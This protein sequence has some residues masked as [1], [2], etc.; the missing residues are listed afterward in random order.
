MMIVLWLLFLM[1]LLLSGLNDTLSMALVVG[2]PT[3]LIPTVLI[4]YA[5][6][7]RITRYVV[8]VALMV[9][10]AL[11]IQQAAGAAELHFGIFV[12]LAFLLCYRDWMVVVIAATTIALHHVSFNFLQQAS[13]GPICFTEPGINILITHAAY[14]VAETLVLC[15]LAVLLHKEALQSAELQASVSILTRG[16]AGT[17]G[18]DQPAMQASSLSGVALQ[19]VISVL[20]TAIINVR[21]EISTMAVASNQIATANSS[22]AVRTE[23]QA[24]SLGTTASS[25]EEIATTVKQTADS[26]DEANKMTAAATKLAVKGG[27]EV[28]QIIATMASINA[29]SRQIADITGVINSIAFQTNILALNAAVEAARAGEQG[30]GFAVVAAEVRSLAQR[31]ATA[32]K[33]IEKLISDSVSQVTAGSSLVSSAGDT[34]NSIVD[35]IHTVDKLVTGIVNASREQSV[36]IE[37]VNYAVSEIDQ[38]TKENAAQVEQAATAALSL[39]QHATSLVS[40]VDVF[41]LDT[42]KESRLLQ[43]IPRLLS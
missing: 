7:Q 37:Q 23:Q 31:S 21:N 26:A 6:G 34:M 36:G 27:Q 38:A 28:G 1:S 16:G 33:D 11:H 15:Y 14:V 35:S 43:A 22:L 41:Q 5:A 3:A 12:L 2:T 39:R 4:V 9:F 25:M 10:C 40:V 30:K 8:A 32:A 29:S 18:L 24:N 20:R 17:I 19:H 42:E 13:Y